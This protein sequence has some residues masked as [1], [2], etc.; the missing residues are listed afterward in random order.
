MSLSII[1]FDMPFDSAESVSIL[2]AEIIKSLFSVSFSAI[3]KVRHSSAFHPPLIL[4]WTLSSPI[5]T[6]TE[7]T[8][9]YFPR[10]LPCLS[11]IFHYSAGRIFNHF[12]KCRRPYT[13]TENC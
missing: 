12:F 8:H 1:A 3:A 2:L 13:Q 4:N 11:Y 7:Y 9:A 6:K 10:L 5:D